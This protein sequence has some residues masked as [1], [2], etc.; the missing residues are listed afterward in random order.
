VKLPLRAFLAVAVSVVIV[1]F[2]ALYLPPLIV[3]K[4]SYEKG[5][6]RGEALAAVGR[7]AA[8][9]GSGGNAESLLPSYARLHPAMDFELLSSDLRVLYSTRPGPERYSLAQLASRLESEWEDESD[10]QSYLRELGGGGEAAYLLARLNSPF[11]LSL[12]RPAL[13]F[14]S[15]ALL[16][17]LLLALLVFGLVLA[18]FSL[19][20]ARRVSRLARAISS[21]APGSLPLPERSRDETGEIARAFNGMS[22]R[23]SSAEKARSEEESARRREEE[24][25][26]ASVANLSHDLRTPL[27]SVLG[28]SE[29]LVSEAYAG[30]EERRRYEEI[31]HAKASYMAGLLDSLLEY[32]RLGSSGPE[33]EAKDFDLCELARSVVIEYLDEAERRGLAI[34]ADIPGEAILVHARSEALSRVLRNLLDNALAYGLSGQGLEVRL[35]AGQGM[36]RLELRDFG[37]GIKESEREKIFERHYRVDPARSSQTGGLG[38]GLPIARAIARREGGDVILE[39]PFDGGCRFVLLLPLHGDFT[40]YSENNTL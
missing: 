4:E 1:F 3:G 30:E 40:R 17:L 15:Q 16:V 9:M 24:E 25:W 27:A 35:R 31:I 10:S 33:A 6:L 14:I 26:R 12:S 32:A 5:H 21:Y 23:L 37:P 19:P 36:S 7:L 11:Y 13:I 34:D 28:Y 20:F 2:L 18:A 38:L 8:E 39:S 22:S 29:S